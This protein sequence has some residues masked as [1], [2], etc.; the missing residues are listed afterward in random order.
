LDWGEKGNEGR[1]KE[2]EKEKG[3]REGT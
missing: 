1:E 3:T 2:A